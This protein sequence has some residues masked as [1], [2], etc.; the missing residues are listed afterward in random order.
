MGT[1]SDRR[2]KPIAIDAES[3]ETGKGMW[4]VPY[5]E[6][7]CWWYVPTAK[8]ND[9]CEVIITTKSGRRR[10]FEIYPIDNSVKF[11]S[12][13]VSFFYLKEI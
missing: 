7:S 6:K 5:F 3:V 12:G 10:T 1:E 9:V 8:T 2:G 13:M 11:C 4:N